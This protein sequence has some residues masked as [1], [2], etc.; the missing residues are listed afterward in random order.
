MV[1]PWRLLQ[2]LLGASS[3]TFA[4]NVSPGPGY[5]WKVQGLAA[6]PKVWAGQ[7]PLACATIRGPPDLLTDL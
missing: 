3:W 6:R 1:G 7:V 2:I 5:D 4:N